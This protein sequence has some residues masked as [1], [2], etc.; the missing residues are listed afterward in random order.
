ML[1][2]VI[3]TTKIIYCLKVKF[4]DIITTDMHAVQWLSDFSLV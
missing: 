4:A 2:H 1:N 3:K